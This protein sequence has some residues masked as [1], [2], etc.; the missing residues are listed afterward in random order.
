MLFPQSLKSGKQLYN[1]LSSIYFVERLMGLVIVR[2]R[3]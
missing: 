3:V 1:H 2:L